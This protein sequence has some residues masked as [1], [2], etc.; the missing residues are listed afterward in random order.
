MDMELM[1]RDVPAAA[2][3][4][5]PATG[6]FTSAVRPLDA[7]HLPVYVRSGNALT[8]DFQRWIHLRSIP[9]TRRGLAQLLERFDVVTPSALSF[10]S[11]GLNLS[12]SYWFRP[13]GSDLTWEDVN[14]YEHDFL[15][16]DVLIAAPDSSV[17]PDYS[18]NGELEKFWMI[19]DGR[20]LLYKDSTAPYFQQAY[21]EVFASRI[22]DLL[23]MDHAAYTLA[24]ANGKTYSVCAA[25]TDERTEYVPAFE[26]LTARKKQNHESAFEH[27]LL[28]TETLGIPLA[29]SDLFGMIAFDFLINNED[30]HYGNFGFLRDAETLRFLGPAPLFD[31]GNSMWYQELTRYAKLADQPA[32]PFAPAQDRQLRLADRT[33][34]DLGA[35]T[36][37]LTEEIFRSVYSADPRMDEERMERLYYNFTQKLRILRALDKA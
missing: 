24:E 2:F 19:R 33:H 36:P 37:A 30:R 26:I 25:F 34:L 31:N 15:P 10:K 11:L 21:N 23:G 13:A 22:L 18:S 3:S 6:A 35:L 28:C 12:D 17:S 7:A 20:R 4:I 16:Q 5:E 32:K 27:F 9:S 8:L 1:H 29:K 14:L